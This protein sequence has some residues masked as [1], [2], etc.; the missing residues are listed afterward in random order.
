MYVDRF[1]NV[2]PSGQKLVCGGCQHELGVLIDYKKEN[3]P[4]YRPFAGA[5]H[6]KAVG[7]N[8]V[9]Q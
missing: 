9:Q 5:A 6:K 3:R 4:A 1:I 2:T 8:K 7:R